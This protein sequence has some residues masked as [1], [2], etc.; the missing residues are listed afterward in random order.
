MSRLEGSASPY[1]R[2][3]AHQPVQ[4]Y[5]WGAE[6]FEV[7]R[8]RDVPVL[9][10][11]GYSTCHWCHV[12]AR[13]SF[14]DERI[15]QLIN[16]G[17]VA[18][19]VDREEHPEVDAAFMAAAS[20]FTRNLGWPLTAFAT[21]DGRTFHAGTYWPP[22]ARG[23]SPG[24]DDVLSAVDQAWRERRG[25]V[26][27][28]AEAV[29]GA[30]STAIAA[31]ETLVPTQGQ[32]DEAAARIASAE[33]PVHGGFG[34][35]GPK[36]PIATALRFLQSHVTPASD[37]AVRA[38]AAMRGSQLFDDVDGG[39]F[40]YTTRPDWTEP[41]FERM[42]TDNAQL[43]DAY[44]AAGEA[45]T[46]RRVAGFLRTILQRP[47]GGFGAAQDAESI[48]D[49]QPSAGGFYRLSASARRHVQAPAVDGKVVTGWNGLAIGALTRF[50]VADGVAAVLA[51]AE[52]AARAVSGTNRVDGEW[53]RAN[54][55]GVAST[56]RATDADLG[57]LATGLFTLA[58]VSAD[59]AFFAQLALELVDTEVAGDPVLAAL[60]IA[61][62]PDQS[63]GDE[64]SAVAA[65]AEAA[66]L[67]SWWGAGD[68]YRQRAEALIAQVA[69]AALAQPRAHGAVLRVASMLVRA[70][71]QVVVVDADLSH[72]LARRAAQLPSD[73]FACVTSEQAAE[74]AGA[75][76]ALFAGKAG[77]NRPTVFVCENFVC[78][79]P[80]TD[81]T[82]LAS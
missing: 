7:A 61:A 35:D 70:P 60:Q 72:P 6:A 4:W 62:A 34:T 15:A 39:F 82:A 21:P 17:F 40:R 67:A 44:V 9:V 43:L 2:A 63:D 20:A 56:A 76:F 75:G 42:L 3:H 18:V 14:S 53:R 74:L 71:R 36:F 57:Q 69:G 65:R 59:A 47:D 13:E 23:G 45:D 77:V 24:F 12:M 8:L 32:L 10:S 80:V 48:I 46:A 5:P 11:I 66:L 26:L 1:L 49:G 58:G 33:D 41:H 30:L 52:R 73:V 31:P 79:L 81:V 54:L 37:V 22:T 78:R 29:Q 25:P 19:K 55:D 68:E 50:A 64:P 38:L 28:I 16:R 27:E 51:A